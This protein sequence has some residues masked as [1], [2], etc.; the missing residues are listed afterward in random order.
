MAKKPSLKI[1]RAALL[2]SV[3]H[4]VRPIQAHHTTIMFVLLMGVLI[5]SVVLVSSA[6]QPTED[7][8]YRATAEAKSITTQFD[9]ATIEKVDNLRQ[10]NDNEAIQLPS[11]RRNPFVD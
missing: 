5:Y 9:Q 8:E 2:E 4:L 3:K 1:D 6:I 10:H 11:G 7:S